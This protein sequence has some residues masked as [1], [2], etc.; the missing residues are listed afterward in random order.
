M[1]AQFCFQRS[2]RRDFLALIFFW[3]QN[4]STIFWRTYSPELTE[5]WTFLNIP[6][7]CMSFLVLL[8][9]YFNFKRSNSN[10]LVYFFPVICFVGP[11]DR[12]RKKYERPQTVE[13]IEPYYSLLFLLHT[14]YS[15]VLGTSYKTIPR[16]EKYVSL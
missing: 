13:E 1:G 14:N 15:Q 5:S 7:G 8:V 11:C 10:N 4:S 3:E 9:Q 2:L 6:S 12:V 16:Q